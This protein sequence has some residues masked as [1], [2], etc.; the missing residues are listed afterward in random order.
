MANLIPRATYRWQFHSGF[1]FKQAKELVGYL[2]ELGVSHVYASP[3][4]QASPGTLHGY[5]VSNPNELNSE[6][7]SRAEF[8]ELTAELKSRGMGLIVDFV[9]NHM[10]IGDNGNTWWMDVL[11]HGQASP[12]A[13]YFDIEWDPLKAEMKDKILCPILAD[14]Y[15]RVLES[16]RFQI[17]FRAGVFRLKYEDF[18]LPL[19]P[20]STLPLLI[21][22]SE[23]LDPAPDE[24]VSIITA[25][26]NLPLA[27][28]RDAERVAER[29]RETR[30]TQNRL[31]MLTQES[32]GVETAIQQAMAEWQQVGD[33]ASM[34]RLDALLTAQ[35][36]RLSSWRVASEEI[37]Y[38]RFFDVNT[39]AGIRVEVPEVF[40]ST[41][42]FLM[43][44]VEKGQIQGIRLDHID[45]LALPLAYLEALREQVNQRLPDEESRQTFYIVVEKILT[46]DERLRGTWPIHGTTGY[47]FASEALRVLLDAKAEKALQNM[48]EDL[49][50]LSTPYRE[51][52]YRSKRLVMQTSLASE[53]NMLGI[54]LSKL[55]QSHRW[56]R[57]FTLNALTTAVR[58]V[59]ACFPV[60]RTYIVP[61]APIDE[62]DAMVLTRAITQA[63]RRNPALERSMFEFLAKVLVPANPDERPLNEELRRLFVL[64][65]QQ[66][67]G[68]V[69]AKGVEDTAFYVFNRFVAL[70]EVGNSPGAFGLSVEAFHRQCAQRQEFPH[71]ML[72]TSTHDT[73]RSEDVRARLAALSEA[74]QAW[75]RVVQRW[76]AVNA[77]LKRKVHGENAP[78]DN[79]EFM[80]YQTIVGSW[81][82]MRMD[83]DERAVYLRRIQ[84]YMLKAIREAKV[85]SSWIEPDESWHDA[86]RGFIAD[87]LNPELD[88]PLP[89]FVL[90]HIQRV[91]ALGA[92]NALAQTALKFTV[93]GVPDTYQGTE[94]WDFSLVDPDNRRAVDYTRRRELLG[95]L[96]DSPK[97]LVRHWRDGRIKLLVMRNLL[98]LR[99]QNPALFRDGTYEGCKTSGAFAE[100]CLCFERHHQG[101]TLLVIV[102]R[103]SSTVGFPP[104]GQHWRDTAVLP[105]AMPGQW[106]NIFTGVR[107]AGAPEL[108][109]AEVLKDLPVAV[110]VSA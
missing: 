13:K 89:D 103:L 96:N 87:I 29:L 50:G 16:G 73:K 7:G 85:N 54:M 27:A 101:L 55:A 64:K 22:A 66:C 34:D 102:P 24:L 14:Q 26:K 70:N 61:D 43:E 107:M 83:A 63:R 108:P 48:Y 72:A 84:D 71:A 23:L 74:P 32:P 82:L 30:V 110:L 81:P 51:I 11:E 2:H 65:F 41:H 28:E 62:A 86:L 67:T 47:E 37:N 58:E 36:Y 93:P 68:P 19:S 25:L 60:Y 33:A 38:R 92:V 106:R 94:L 45:G 10:G 104:L 90:R 42:T 12:Y 53:V 105:A 95:R 97:H 69:T 5:D 57:D 31:A 21:R 100:H 52:I 76:K 4:F 78:D 46:G 20:R 49:A 109:L 18:L 88:Q 35:I 17:V 8:D 99:R 91:S 77:P 15:G 39:L 3:I 56:Y 75:E 98:D 40:Q 59:I 44:L 9:P 79:E 1:T 80:L 6:I